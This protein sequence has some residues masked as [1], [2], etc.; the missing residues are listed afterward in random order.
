MEKIIVSLIQMQQQMRIFHWQTKSYARHVAFGEAY[1]TL[2][3][4]E[5]GN[6]IVNAIGAVSN[7]TKK[8]STHYSVPFIVKS[9]IS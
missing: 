2:S 7:L 9:I 6:I 8:M 5:A 3:K 1:D 4:R